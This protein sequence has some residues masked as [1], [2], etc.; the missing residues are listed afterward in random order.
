MEKANKLLEKCGSGITVI[1][2]YTVNLLFFS[3]ILFLYFISSAS[4]T[5]LIKDDEG[6]H[7]FISDHPILTLILIA[8]IITVFTAIK[9]SRKVKDFLDRIKK[10]ES[11]FNK[12]RFTMIAIIGILSLLWAFSTQF[13][14]NSDQM[15]IQSAV[16]ELR[17]E[18]YT[19][20]VPGE[21]FYIYPNQ[22]GLV[23]LSYFFSVFFGSSNYLVFSVF[24]V[25]AIMFFYYSLSELCGSYN[26]GRTAQISVI[27][28]GFLFYP[29][30]IYSCYIYGTIA[31]LAFGVAA[32]DME[33]KY[34][35]NGKRRNAI[36]CAVFIM[37]AI[38]I[39]SNFSIFLIALFICA[40]IE[41]IRTKQIKQ[42]LL[43]GLLAAAMLVSS[44]LPTFI[45]SQITHVDFDGGASAWGWVAM[46]IRE[47]DRAPGAFNYTNM[48]L[49]SQSE[50]DHDRHA[51]L[52]KE[53]V[54]ER[55]EYFRENIP[56]AISFFTRKQ[57]YQWGDPTFQSLWYIREKKSLIELSDWVRFM[58]TSRGEKF[59]LIL[60]NPL[61]TFIY[62][63]ALLYC[64]ICRS[65]TNIHT[66][67]L[68]MSFIGG[69]VF[70]TFWEAAPRY[71]LP[72]F[73]LLFPITIAG[74]FKLIQLLSQRKKKGI[75]EL[76]KTQKGRQTL[77][78]K[79]LSIMP[80]LLIAVVVIT[81][82]GIF[83]GID[84]SLTADNENYSEWLETASEK[85]IVKEGNYLL[86]AG[87]DKAITLGNMANDDESYD[88]K[89]SKD[90]TSI[91]IVYYNGNYWLK[92]PDKQLYISAD[93]SSD[94][95]TAIQS[96]HDVDSRKWEV[97]EVEDHKDYV[98]F[99][100][101]KT[102][103]LTYD[104]KNNTVY[105]SKFKGSMNQIWYLM[106]D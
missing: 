87:I 9:D 52:A 70:H 77:Q 42:I 56:E 93:N 10:D 81:T 68:P 16:N 2:R 34:F 39:K 58:K 95:I 53:S 71:T 6:G 48:D 41:I 14:P 103:A 76:L 97:L 55:M 92:L 33:I 75:S 40:V 85:Q 32:M 4:T 90:P 94:K 62:L 31:G 8:G 17:K 30:I 91:R 38:I 26:F 88:L 27:A 44:A 74:Y 102:Y 43:P 29:L 101:N 12:V 19:Y 5:I 28:M 24:N 49:Y 45:I 20:F 21:Y 11:Y 3:I 60:L 54:E 22:F 57:A 86:Y 105:L 7:L 99:V 46:G 63:G 83:F 98:C 61:L 59:S 50:C 47:G 89:L 72:F 96:D 69:Y 78:V 51:E 84:P 65:K 106:K 104:S 35:L 36:A 64:I 13:I 80:Y 25:A 37:L 1:Y 23:L 82:V 66:L 73:V 67:I 79:Y 18:N 15:R 100:Y